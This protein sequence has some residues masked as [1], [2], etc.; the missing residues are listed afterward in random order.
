M[1]SLGGNRCSLEKEERCNQEIA[2]V[3]IAVLTVARIGGSS[4]NFMHPPSSRDSIRTVGRFSLC[5][6][7]AS[8]FKLRTAGVLALVGQAQSVHG[9]RE[10]IAARLA[11]DKGLGSV[12]YL[13]RHA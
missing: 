11:S 10:S 1:E 13:F 12:S 8:F 2:G 7:V 4:G 9:Y 5:D 6:M 3:A